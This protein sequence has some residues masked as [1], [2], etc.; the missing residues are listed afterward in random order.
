MRPKKIL[1][2][3]DDADDQDFF[4]DFIKSRTDVVLVS[5]AKNGEEVFDSLSGTRVPG[6]LPD[7]IIL[8]QNMPKRNGMQ[9]LQMLKENSSYAAIPVFIYSTYADAVLQQQS[10]DAG[11]I[12]VFPK[13]YTPEGYHNMINAMLDLLK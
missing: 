4:S 7:L 12:S 10:A 3:E 1:L 11:A 8:D 6:N 5:V 13:P 2:A 9:T